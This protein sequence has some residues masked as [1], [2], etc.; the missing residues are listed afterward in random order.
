MIYM[1]KQLAP[2][3]YAQHNG[4]LLQ[5]LWGITLRKKKTKIHI[6]HDIYFYNTRPRASHITFNDWR[7]QKNY[8]Y[9]NTSKWPSELPSTRPQQFESGN[10]AS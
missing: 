9:G 10:R 8:H 7:F 4:M 6:T 1:T 2:N 3:K 5:L